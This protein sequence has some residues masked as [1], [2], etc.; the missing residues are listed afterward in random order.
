MR[1][2]QRDAVADRQ[3]VPPR[4]DL[5]EPGENPLCDRG[6]QLA[7]RVLR[8]VDRQLGPVPGP[9]LPHLV[10]HVGQ[11]FG[12][13]DVGVLLRRLRR[14]AQASPPLLSAPRQ[15]LTL[16][17][18]GRPE[19]GAVACGDSAEDT[20]LD[21]RLRLD[22]EM[23]EVV[24]QIRVVP[25]RLTGRQFGTDAAHDRHRVA[26]LA[27]LGERD[28]HPEDANQTAPKAHPIYTGVGG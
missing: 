12:A 13:C 26:A 22:D 25:G 5:V 7:Q 20:I 9:D 24:W 27:G 1:P 17:R 16:A 3:G 4:A 21:S 28:L 23:H 11:P 6:V 19:N 2:G 10:A 18:I 14:A 8:Y 15:T